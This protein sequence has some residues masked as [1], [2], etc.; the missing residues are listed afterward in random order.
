MQQGSYLTERT[1]ALHLLAGTWYAS[2][3]DCGHELAQG[4]DQEL[5]ERWA[6]ELGPCQ[7]CGEA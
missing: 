4:R 1:I 5:V 7:V 3:P 6:A 2:C